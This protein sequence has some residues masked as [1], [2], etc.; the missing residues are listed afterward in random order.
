MWFGME[1]VKQE[2]GN[3]GYLFSTCYRKG[4]RTSLVFERDSKVSRRVG[5]ASE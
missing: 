2:N 1:A 4:V 5:K 3:R